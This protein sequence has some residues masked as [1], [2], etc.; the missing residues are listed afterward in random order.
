MPRS[1]ASGSSRSAATSRPAPASSFTRRTVPTVYTDFVNRTARRSTRTSGCGW[2]RWRSRSACCHWARRR[3]PAVLR[4]RPRRHQL[5]LQRV[6]RVRRHARPQH[7]Q[8]LVRRVGHRDRAGRAGRDPL[9]RRYAR[10]GFEI[11]Y[12]AAE[13]DLPP[14]FAGRRSIWR[15]V[16]SL[17]RRDAFRSVDARL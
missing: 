9:R 15:L 4:R 6:G 16:L 8:Q 17:H 5:A 13:A 12:Q 11:R 3:L 2:C 10:A 7:L 14:P 1:A